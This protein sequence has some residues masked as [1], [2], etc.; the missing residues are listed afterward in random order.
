ML[1]TPSPACK[2]R[3]GE[4]VG[5][6]VVDKYG[7]AVMNE[8]L[9]GDHRRVRHDTVKMAI[10]S[11]CSWARLPATSEVWRLFSH[12]IPSEALSRFESGERDKEWFQT[13]DSRSYQSLEKP[14]SD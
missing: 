14:G 8:P 13:L 4:K 6:A 10:N 7:N 12:L 1:C 3:V 9:P 5:K 2:D 11:L